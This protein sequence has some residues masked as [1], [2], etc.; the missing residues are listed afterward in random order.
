MARDHRGP[1]LDAL[2]RDARLGAQIAQPVLLLVGRRREL[3][4]GL[5]RRVVV[6]P[7]A[8]AAGVACDRL[9]I[10]EAPCR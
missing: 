8:A 9:N 4:L 7:P 2:V 5:E 1:E 3:A 10:L 6:V